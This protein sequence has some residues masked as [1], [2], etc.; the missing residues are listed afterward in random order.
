MTTGAKE[1]CTSRRL[2]G[3][4]LVCAE[5]SAPPRIVNRGKARVGKA[6]MSARIGL[7]RSMSFADVSA[8]TSALATASS[9]EAAEIM[10]S[11]CE[12]LGYESQGCDP[13]ESLLRAE[14]V[15]PV[16]KA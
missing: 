1:S 14:T 3:V 7:N 9:L 10:S 12:S 2:S 6:R 4:L 13:L 15:L 11:G 16:T 8:V 5:S